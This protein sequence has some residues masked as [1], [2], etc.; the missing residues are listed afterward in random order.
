[1]IEEIKKRIKNRLLP[2]ELTPINDSSCITSID[3]ASQ[4]KQKIKKS[5]DQDAN[6]SDYSPPVNIFNLFYS[7]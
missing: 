7:I 4:Q 6:K 2:A 3:I 1:L 5:H